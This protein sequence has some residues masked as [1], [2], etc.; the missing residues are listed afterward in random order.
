MALAASSAF[1]FPSLMYKKRDSP[2]FSACPL[3]SSFYILFSL[4]YLPATCSRY[5][6]IKKCKGVFP[7]FY[8]FHFPR[9]FFTLSLYQKMQ[10]GFSAFLLI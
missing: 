6:Y 4:V 8:S 10:E 2:L 9:T 1:P 7:R 3:S 5:H